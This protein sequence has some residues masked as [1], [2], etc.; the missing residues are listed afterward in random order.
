MLLWFFYAFG[1]L[2]ITHDTSK[3]IP[4]NLRY[5]QESIQLVG[6]SADTHV[7]TNQLP[8]HNSVPGGC[9]LL[10]VVL[11]LLVA[12]FLLVWLERVILWLLVHR[13]VA[14]TPSPPIVCCSCCWLTTV[15]SLLR[16]SVSLMTLLRGSQK[17]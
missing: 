13:M 5:Y 10:E 11:V 7:C 17:P 3:W 12:R 9:Q 4:V 16:I 8:V 1:N 2:S 15:L 6:D 14:R